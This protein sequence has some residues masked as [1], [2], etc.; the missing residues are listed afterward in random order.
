MS[1]KILSLSQ[2]SQRAIEIRQAGQRLVLTNGC[3]DLL[4]VGHVR[5]LQQARELGDFL[6]VAVNGDESVRSLKGAGRPLNSEE[7]RAEV[8]AALECVDF[9]TIFP[10]QRATAVIEALR[11]ATYV[12]GGDYTVESLDPE[13]VAAL[14]QAGAE[15]RT[16]ALVPGKSTSGLIERLRP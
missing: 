4:H 5:Y 2:L 16:L 15:I 13:E 3:F 1:A 11:P 8:L 10:A 6:V 7:D 14:K 9:V 12:K